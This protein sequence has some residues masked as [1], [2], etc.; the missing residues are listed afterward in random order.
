MLKSPD[1]VHH[2]DNGGIQKRITISSSGRFIRR[3]YCAI[4]LRSI[5]PQYKRLLKRH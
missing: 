4:A 1:L 5:F 2:I 3:L